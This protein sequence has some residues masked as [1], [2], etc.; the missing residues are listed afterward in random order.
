MFITR[1]FPV[2][3]L[4]FRMRFPLDMVCL[5]HICNTCI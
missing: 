3:S 5:F 4:Q 1:S 2:R